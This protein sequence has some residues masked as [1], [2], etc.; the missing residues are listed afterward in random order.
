MPVDERSDISQTLLPAGY[1]VTY[2]IIHIYY[3]FK[4][5]LTSL[6]I[7]FSENNESGAN[8]ELNVCY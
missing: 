1:M 6:F 3:Y 8:N 2:Y 4:S 7:M 5:L